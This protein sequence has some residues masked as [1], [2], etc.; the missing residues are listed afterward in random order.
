MLSGQEWRPAAT[1]DFLVQGLVSSVL[2][3]EDEARRAVA[4]DILGDILLSMTYLKIREPDEEQEAFDRKWDEIMSRIDRPSE[5]NNGN[6][7]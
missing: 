6:E 7:D 2:E 3:G 5:E 1:L 4:K